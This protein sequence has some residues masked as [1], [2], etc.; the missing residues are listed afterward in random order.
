VSLV[1]NVRG[2]KRLPV[3]QMLKTIIA[4]VAAWYTALLVVPGE[5][6]I[7]A[8][9]AAIIVVQPSVNQSIGKALERSIGTI[10]GVIVALGASMAFGAPGWL[11]I[12]AISVAIFLGW[13]FK[14]TA[15]TSNQIAIS[16]MLVIVIGAATPTYAL[17]R[18]LET[19]VG[20]IV[21]LIINAIIVPPVALKPAVDAT[22]TLTDHV[23]SVLEDMGAVLTRETSDE[24]I[25]TIYLRAR[26]LRGELNTAR[27][28]V[29]KARE[30]M[31][32]NVLRG[33]KS[34]EI[35]AYIAFIDLDAVLVTRTIGLARAL[36][37]HYDASLTREPAIKEIAE[38][39]GSAGHD[40]R[41]RARDAH[42][43]AITVPHPPTSELPALT[44][45]ITLKAPTGANWVLVGFLLESLRRIRAEIVG[46]ETD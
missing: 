24:V 15:A 20:V 16:A 1:S 9:M 34:R 42:L 18:I 26:A 25:E 46:V 11:V 2:K 19:L 31:R 6:P 7:F 17:H 22:A 21:G 12:V 38:E 10:L 8:V 5:K 44:S 36:R 40:L 39:L 4:A 30:S 27:T 3:L 29:E 45:P 23:A 14:F 28:T 13:L 35:E 41:M 43:P 33:R 37:D 32:F